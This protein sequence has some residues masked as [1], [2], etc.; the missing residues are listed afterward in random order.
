M[1]E[2]QVLFPA[3]IALLFGGM[4][5]AAGGIFMLAIQYRRFGRLSMVHTLATA[6]TVIYL[7]AV[8]AYTMLPLPASKAASCAANTGGVELDPLGPLR[9]LREVFAPGISHALHSG[10]FWQLALNV[11]LF[12]PF[13]ILAVRLLGMHPVAAVMLGALASLTIEATQYTG[14]FGLFCRY[15]VADVGDLETN[16][17]GTLIGVLLALTPLFRWIHTPQQLEASA[18]WRPVTRGRRLWGMIFDLAFITAAIAFAGVLQALALEPAVRNFLGTS[19]DTM[20]TVSNAAWVLPAAVVLLPL[21]GARRASLGQRCVWLDVSVPDGGRAPLALGLWRALLGTGGYAVLSIAEG[22]VTGAPAW[23]GT[24]S[25][26]WILAAGIFLLFDRS[27][28]GLSARGSGLDFAP[29]S[30]PDSAPPR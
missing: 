24:L 11:I 10:M 23:L 17:L 21:L 5:L 25:G 16:T 3:E 6:G 22:L 7:F 20:R 30:A 2:S 18:Q 12:I 13:G 28:R 14:L 19:Q 29:R 1:S 4:A 9:Q 8:G 26:A 15:R 27:G